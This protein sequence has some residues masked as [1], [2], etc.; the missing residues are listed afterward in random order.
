M[1]SDSEKLV[2]VSNALSDTN[3]GKSDVDDFTYSY[4]VSIPFFLFCLTVLS[5]DETFSFL[6]QE[7]L[8]RL[9]LRL[10]LSLITHQSVCV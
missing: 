3:S 2:Q 1:A 6:V 8:V 5:A 9:I 10:H 7:Q 4:W